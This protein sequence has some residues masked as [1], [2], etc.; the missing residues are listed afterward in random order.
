MTDISE[1]D[2]SRDFRVSGFKPCQILQDV[3]M[4]VSERQRLRTAPVSGFMEVFDTELN[5][6]EALIWRGLNADHDWATRPLDV[7]R[8][9][10]V[11]PAMKDATP[12]QWARKL[13]EAHAA[14]EEMP[15]RYRD[16]DSHDKKRM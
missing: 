15:L 3:T 11:R 4:M 6:R 7:V 2:R 8:L 16:M 10:M 13:E 12:E 5:Q 14:M 1:N 9:V